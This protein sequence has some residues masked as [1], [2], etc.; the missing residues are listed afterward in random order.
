LSNYTKTTD[1]AIKDGLATGNPA[2]I[3]KGTEHDTEY[4]NIAT[5]VTSKA[6][7]AS[8]VFT[9]TPTAPNPATG[10]RSTQLATTQKFT[11][12]FVS[13][14]STSGY[15]KFPT[16]LIIQWGIATSSDLG[17]G[18]NTIAV[19]FPIAF[20]TNSTPVVTVT[21]D[22]SQQAY[23]RANNRPATG[24]NI[25]AIESTA[26]VASHSFTWMAIGN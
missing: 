4:N 15:Q 21:D 20:P 14:I 22:S 6:D 25:I 24:F 8:P 12:E 11:D 5:A 17:S 18:D 7:L 10:N 23:L 1:F 2:K 13:S 3:I 26:V 16:G 9:G 19:T